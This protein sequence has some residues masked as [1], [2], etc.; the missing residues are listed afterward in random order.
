VA[1]ASGQFFDVPSNLCSRATNE[2]VISYSCEIKI[3]FEDSNNSLK[4]S[5]I[6][7]YKDAKAKAIIAS[8]DFPLRLPLP[9]GRDL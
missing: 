9:A 1:V 8:K 2:I 7:C 6:D 5:R 3:R 4:N